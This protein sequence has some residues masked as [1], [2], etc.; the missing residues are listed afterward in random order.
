MEFLMFSIF[1]KITANWKAG[2]WAYGLNSCPR[3][4]KL[5]QE[6]ENQV[7]LAFVLG[8]SLYCKTRGIFQT[9]EQDSNTE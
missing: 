8:L 4:K 3:F 7:V 1:F 2:I 5:D 9:Q 6:D